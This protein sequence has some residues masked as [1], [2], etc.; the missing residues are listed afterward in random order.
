MRLTR[1]TVGGGGP[2]ELRTDTCAVHVRMT[3]LSPTLIVRGEY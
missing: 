1:V 2:W 3:V